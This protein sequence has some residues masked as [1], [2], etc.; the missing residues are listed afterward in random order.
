MSGKI[1]Y[2]TYKKYT[3]TIGIC[4]QTKKRNGQFLFYGVNLYKNKNYLFYSLDNSMKGLKLAR[5]NN[6]T[7][8]EALNF[9]NIGDMP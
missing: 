6:L 9:L 1:I 5:E 2:A 4:G 3:L 7:Q 8:Q